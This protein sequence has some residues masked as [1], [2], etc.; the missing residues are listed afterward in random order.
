MGERGLERLFLL[1]IFIFK[2]NIKTLK[3]TQILKLL[4]CLIQKHMEMLLI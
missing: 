2:N 3:T 1:C 4:I